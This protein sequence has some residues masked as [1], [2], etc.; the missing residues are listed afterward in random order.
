LRSTIIFKSIGKVQSDFGE[1]NG[2]GRPSIKRVMMVSLAVSARFSTA[3]DGI[4]TYIIYHINM[5]SWMKGLRIH[6][7]GRKEFTKIGLFVTRSP[8]RPNTIGFTVVKMLEE[9]S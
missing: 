6:P 7:Q 4:H 3:P 8:Y 9:R 1:E 5:V 2:I